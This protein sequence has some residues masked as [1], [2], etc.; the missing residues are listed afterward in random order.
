MTR[1]QA[2]LVALSLG[3]LGAAVAK[4]NTPTW[5]QR[6]DAFTA[7]ANRERAKLGAAANEAASG[8]PELILSGRDDE[9]VVH[10]GETVEVV[11]TGTIQKASL[12][13]FQCNALEVLSM[14]QTEGEVRAK[15]R[16]SKAMLPQVCDLQVTAPVSLR[17]ASTPAVRVVGDYAWALKL[18]NGLESRWT[19]KTDENGELTGESEWFKAGKLL[20]KYPLQFHVS[21]DEVDVDVERTRDDVNAVM[22]ASKS[23]QEGQDNEALV[24][25]MTAL[26]EKMQKDCAA[27]P[28]AKL[29]GCFERYQKQL[30]PLQQRM[31]TNGEASAAAVDVHPNA[32]LKLHL[33]VGADGK[34]TGKG[35]GCQK[36]GEL[37]LTGTVA[38][39]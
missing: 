21:D 19:A 26:M 34:V 32:C 38:G 25:Q 17:A 28:S 15:V 36:A 6:L 4:T 35:V 12:A 14:K 23:V 27:L 7:Q 39:R 30:E 31:Q 16:A 10:P 18:G 2:A 24:K 13:L 33:Q 8:T 37:A 1:V 5:Q 29:A 20:G 11:A 9:W 3:A 22:T